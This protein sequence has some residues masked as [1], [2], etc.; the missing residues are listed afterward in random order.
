MDTDAMTLTDL[1]AVLAQLPA[2]TV[3]ILDGPHHG[4]LEDQQGVL[5]QSFTTW[6]GLRGAM[7][8]TAAE[9]PEA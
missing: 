6:E 3:V 7:Q 5:V 2:D 8:A 4:W 1:D 9:E